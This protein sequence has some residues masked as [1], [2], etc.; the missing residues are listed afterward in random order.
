[1]E[2]LK[3]QRWI[4]AGV[5]AL[6]MC[7]VVLIFVRENR[8]I[9]PG[10]TVWVEMAHAGPLTQGSKVRVAGLVVGMVEQVSFLRQPKAGVEDA[11]RVT[12]RLWISKRHA[13]LLH[14]KSEYFVNQPGLLSEPYLEVGVPRQGDP[15]PEIKNGAVVRGVDPSSLDALLTKSYALLRAM[16][17]TL[18][19]EFPEFAELGTEIDALDATFT[20]LARHPAVSGTGL[21]HLI[22]EGARTKL[23]WNEVSGELDGLPGTVER[24]RALVEHG[25]AAVTQLRG[26][27]DALTA[28]LSTLRSQLDPAR[29]AKIEEALARVDVLTR[30]LEDALAS[31]DA[32]AVL[33]ASGQGS[34]AAFAQDMEI[35]DEVKAVTKML[36]EQPWLL[37]H[38]QD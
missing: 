22:V 26:H 3:N 38:P 31:A 15:G 16:G 35:A 37:G 12:L 14:E 17:D 13:W 27:I 20:E 25:R 5:I 4:G 1:M 24:A 34:L 8:K 7:V 6:V 36:K 29:M 9:G 19:K 28:R 10:L 18:H 2:E 33:V 23:W 32:L 11:P 30:H 21:A